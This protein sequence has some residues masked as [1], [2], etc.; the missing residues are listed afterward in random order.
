MPTG[1][2]SL[3]T[4][5]VRKSSP[6]PGL[7]KNTVLWQHRTKI[8]RQMRSQIFCQM[9]QKAECILCVCTSIFV[10]YDGKYVGQMTC[11]IARCSLC[12]VALN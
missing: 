7:S 3:Y 2:F 1:L 6:F 4:I 5:F 11:K 12:G 8:V 10:K 9:K